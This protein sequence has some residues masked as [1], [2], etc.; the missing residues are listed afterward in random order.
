MNSRDK[1]VSISRGGTQLNRQTGQGN[2][3]M[4]R[5]SPTAPPVYRPQQVPKVLQPK[6]LSGVAQLMESRKRL[7]GKIG[8]LAKPEAADDYP[9]PR[10]AR[11]ERLYALIP[12]ED[13]ER[14]NKGYLNRTVTQLLSKGTASGPPDVMTP[15]AVAT[16]K[17]R[18]LSLVG[19][20]YGDYGASCRKLVP[21]M[22]EFAV[23]KG[24]DVRDV[25]V[26][27]L[28]HSILVTMEGLNYTTTIGNYKGSWRGGGYQ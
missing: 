26:L 1:R 27:K 20:G 9:L 25:A 13:P 8:H 5:K 17:E 15:T 19:T 28:L 6:K 22:I 14:A 24:Y 18:L 10:P 4:N 3:P 2:A 16:A 7:Y 11:V 23:D 21:N 12:E